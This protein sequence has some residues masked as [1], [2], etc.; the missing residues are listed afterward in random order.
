M[1][2][3]IHLDSNSHRLFIK[4]K[5]TRYYGYKV[6]ELPRAFNRTESDFI[7]LLGF[8]FTTATNKRP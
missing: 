5:R 8:T 2:F 1:H 6:G 7:N 3:K 4:Y